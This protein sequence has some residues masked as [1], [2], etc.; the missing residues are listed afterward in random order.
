MESPALRL[1]DQACQARTAALERL[2]DQKPLDIE[3]LKG[4]LTHAPRPKS[5]TTSV[6][7]DLAPI[8]QSVG[9]LTKC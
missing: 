6:V 1:Y 8:A 4:M 3:S 7:S 5:A 9:V 2:V